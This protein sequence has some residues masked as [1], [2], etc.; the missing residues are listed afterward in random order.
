MEDTNNLLEYFHKL[1]QARLCA[2]LHGKHIIETEAKRVKGEILFYE[3]M[4][5]GEGVSNWN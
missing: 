1:N 2:D 5:G 4:R 3:S